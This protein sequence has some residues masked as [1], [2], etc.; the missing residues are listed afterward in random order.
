MTSFAKSTAV[1]G[2]RWMPCIATMDVTADICD[3]T[4]YD[5]AVLREELRANGT[6][7]LGHCSGLDPYQAALFLEDC[8][9]SL[10]DISE[11]EA[12]AATVRNCHDFLHD[13]FDDE[14]QRMSRRLMWEDDVLLA[15][16]E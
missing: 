6:R 11:A 16:E 15:D 3:D 2:V 13:L 1:I 9:Q 14:G 10:Q 12:I 5:V 8:E 7:I 4:A